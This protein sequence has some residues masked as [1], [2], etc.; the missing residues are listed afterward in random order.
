MTTN[1]PELLDSALIRSGRIDYKIEFTFA[2]LKDVYDILKF[3]WNET[4]IDLPNFDVHLK[5]SHA[6]IINFCR[7]SNSLLETCQKIL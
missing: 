7:T 4:Q 1:K 3:Y 2:T 5:Y 6:D